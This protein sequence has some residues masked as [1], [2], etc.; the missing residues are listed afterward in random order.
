MKVEIMSSVWKGHFVIIM[1]IN[2]LA[3]ERRNYDDSRR[4]QSANKK[5]SQNE[6]EEDINIMFI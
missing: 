2:L 5:T 6:N 1:A 3:Y 4:F